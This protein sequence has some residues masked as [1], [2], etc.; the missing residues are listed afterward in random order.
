MKVAALVL[1]LVW[2]GAAWAQDVS[3]RGGEHETFS[4]LVLRVPRGAPWSLEPA[5]GGYDLQLPPS[6]MFDVSRAFDKIPRNRV[7]LLTPWGDGRLRLSVPCDCHAQA[8]LV[9]DV[10]LVV[11]VIDGP[12]PLG[13]IAPG[14]R[15]AAPLT[16]MGMLP[17]LT[18][19][20]PVAPALGPLASLARVTEAPP[21]EEAAPTEAE[22]VDQTRLAI[23]EG[24]AQ[25][26]TEGF[27]DLDPSAQDQEPVL[28]GEDPA[29]STTVKHDQVPDS[30]HPNP[31]VTPEE[32]VGGP[33]RPGVAF[34]T[35]SDVPS[36]R[37][38]LGARGTTCLPDESFDL[39]AW[40][41]EGDFKTELPARL[42]QVT[43][44]RDRL[45]PNGVEDLAQAYLAFGFGREAL[46]ALSM[47]GASSR[48][49]DLLR[50]MARIVDDEPV[51]T[52]AMDDQASC[53]GKVSLWRALARKSIRMTGDGERTAM[54]LALRALPDEVRSL[55]APRLAGLFLDQGDALAAR[56]IAALAEHGG[57]AVELAQAA[58]V[59]EIEGP[60]PALE[61]LETIAESDPRM[62]PDAMVDL[63]DLSIEEGRS[64]SDNTL[65]L[66]RA[67]R[68]ENEGEGARA[69][70]LAEAR[71]L[72]A[73][74]RFDEAL[75]LLEDERQLNPAEDVN[76]ALVATVVALTE[77]LDDASFLEL[78]LGALPEGLPSAAVDPVARRLA[79]LGF[80]Q[81]AWSL[82]APPALPSAAP[83][84][85]EAEADRTVSAARPPVEEPLQEE[86]DDQEPVAGALVLP[87]GQEP[88]Q[89]AALADDPAPPAE[90]ETALPQLSALP[91][92][93]ILAE[94]LPVAPGQEVEPPVLPVPIAVPA[95]PQPLPTEAATPEPIPPATV[96]AAAPAV[97]A[98]NP[99]VPLPENA[100]MTLA[101][102]RELLGRAQE[103]RARAA[104]LLA[105][106]PIE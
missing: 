66:A 8:Y 51:P 35:A 80:P 26:A 15:L 27:L 102:R 50:L 47:D 4:R 7:A 95:S 42:A 90:R 33:A 69:L 43:D 44:G 84:E 93:P 46:T 34:H 37:P 73:D 60:G 74:M 54:T 75:A 101:E 83:L 24:M 82:R 59:E 6:V 57:T 28:S 36:T 2:G 106:A 12:P 48:E 49:R 40:A 29:P 13:G 92:L 87:E 76:E 17:L 81:E 78:A 88:D 104:A 97:P 21:A 23:L 20:L 86:P 100:L 63:I 1:A 103:A 98:A 32:A 61:E 30:P 19:T 55:L 18:E 68:F 62:T 58:I 79:E 67:L 77:K 105:A 64:V 31:A 10:D 94:P 14:D 89:Q 56:D 25:A 96:L 16:G 72:T 11:D 70:L 65:E 41:G 53:L 45:D 9:S 38:T 99:A 91:P 52:D 85:P 5:P 71:A 22:R 39:T 3:V